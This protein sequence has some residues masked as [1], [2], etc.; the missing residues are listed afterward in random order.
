[1]AQDISCPE[2]HQGFGK[3]KESPFHMGCDNCGHEFINHNGYIEEDEQESDEE[4]AAHRA[5]ANEHL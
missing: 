3:D 2:C 4:Q 5:F 1:M